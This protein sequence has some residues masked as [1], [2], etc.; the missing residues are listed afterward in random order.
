[1]APNRKKSLAEKE[2]SD[3]LEQRYHV[4][5]LVRDSID[6]LG[7]WAQPCKPLLNQLEEILAITFDEYPPQNHPD[8]EGA[9]RKKL[10]AHKIRA[11]A[12]RCRSEQN[13]EAGWIN[14]VASLLF[15]CINDI[16]SIW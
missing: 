16:D 9:C 3:V 2:T 15:D 6:R 7:L 14:N 10:V 8:I 4:S 5:F 11:N 12:H 1:M 13:N